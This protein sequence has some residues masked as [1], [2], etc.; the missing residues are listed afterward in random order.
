MT[1]VKFG[2]CVS[3]SL[4]L[5]L[6]GVVLTGAVKFGRT[7]SGDSAPPVVLSLIPIVEEPLAPEPNLP[8]SEPLQPTE[9]PVT[10]PKPA[11]AIES[12]VPREV[13]QPIPNRVKA[14]DAPMSE[15]LPLTKDR[16]DTSATSPST[17]N[18]AP[19]SEDESKKPGF[20]GARSHAN[21]RNNPKTVYPLSAQR[22][23][24]EGVVVLKVKV[25][26]LGRVESISVKQTSGVDV[27]DE[28]AIKAVRGW[29]FEPARIGSKAVDSEV[30]VPFNFTLR[31]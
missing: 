25:T 26:A 1:P 30:D 12:I 20:V 27:L 3:I 24:Q 15:V 2:F 28:A 17:Q 31:K 5:V 8:P 23:K 9:P 29:D 7:P 14:T 6:A 4:H 10:P 16:P 13:V 11:P 22:R 19:P 21:Y 18:A